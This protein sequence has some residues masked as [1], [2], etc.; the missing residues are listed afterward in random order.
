MAATSP[1][2]ADSALKIMR[3]KMEQAKSEYVTDHELAM[4]KRI[5]NIMEDVYYSQTSSAQADL[6][7]QYE[8]L[9]LG[10]NYRDSMRDKI[11]AVTKEDVRRVAQKY[12]THSA[13]LLVKP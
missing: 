7:S 3:E 11:N 6:A 4:G 10:Y 9:G 8:V 5:C 2:T 1:A 12:L 13:T